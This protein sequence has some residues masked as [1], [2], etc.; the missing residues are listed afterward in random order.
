MD[1]KADLNTKFLS[2]YF[3]LSHSCCSIREGGCAT[4]FRHVEPTEYIPRLL[5]FN[6]K[7][8][9]IT[10]TEVPISRNAP[11]K[12]TDTY[13]LF[14]LRYFTFWLVFLQVPCNRARLVSEDVFIYD[15]GKVIY[16]WNGTG[17]NKDEQFKVRTVSLQCICM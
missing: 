5:R 12:H 11:S 3:L 13:Q 6:G 2:I 14:A 16:Q 9:N 8:S 17:A 10:V 15:G 1:L 4:G 7:R